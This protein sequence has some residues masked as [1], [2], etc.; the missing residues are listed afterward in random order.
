MAETDQVVRLV[1]ERMKTYEDGLWGGVAMLKS[2]GHDVNGPTWLRF[3]SSLSIERRYPGNR[4]VGIIHRVPRAELAGYIAR[5]RVHRADFKVHPTRDGAVYYPIT[6][7]EPIAKNARALGL[8]IGHEIN[9]RTALER[10]RDTGEAQ[11]TGPI[12]LVQ[13]AGSTPGFLL[14]TPVYSSHVETVQERRASFVGAIYSPIVMRELMEGT[15]ARGNR[16]VMFSIHDGEELLYDEHVHDADRD[17]DPLFT[18]HMEVDLNGRTWAF[19]VRTTKTYRELASNSQP[20]TILVGGLVLDSLL[21]MF[22]LSMAR[23]NQR[24]IAYADELTSELQRKAETLL[25]SNR[26]LEQLSFLASHDLKSPL[27]GIVALTGFIEED[28]EGKL[29]AES[30]SHLK[31]V[32]SLA[33]RMFELLDELLK[34]AALVN[35][36]ENS[37]TQMCAVGELVQ[38]VCELNSL[39]V[40]RLVVDDQA[41]RQSVSGFVL[42]AVLN[43]LVSNAFKYGHG[44]DGNLPTCHV[45]TWLEGRDLMISVRDF[46]AGIPAGK[47]EVVFD[48]FRQLQAKEDGE[49]SGVG[50]AVVRRL[51]INAGGSVWVEAAEGSKQEGPGANFMVRWPLAAVSTEGWGST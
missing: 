7:I 2:H 26:D 22:F 16:H 40:N 31:N 33:N 49:G 46:G 11:V 47:E 6:F 37:P 41:G 5:H 3:A 42:K 48:I 51:V 43:N 44:N 1:E 35:S 21:L 45:T 19:D 39:D 36:G 34:Y 25:R 27:R 32:Q 50:L 24:T 23:A 38:E 29:P 17:D 4:G 20:W 13:D 15:L 30:A 8:D 28:L 14:Y 9:R 18:R 10:A 12:V